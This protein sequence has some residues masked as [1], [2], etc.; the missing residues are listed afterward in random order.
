M[1][2]IHNSDQYRRMVEQLSSLKG[3]GECLMLIRPRKSIGASAKNAREIGGSGRAEPLRGA[4]AVWA[5]R[6]TAPARAR[7]GAAEA[8]GPRA[9]GTTRRVATRSAVEAGGA[10]P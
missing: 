3:R 9:G 1:Y 5:G 7:V 8:P 2:V 10:A 6:G 4:A